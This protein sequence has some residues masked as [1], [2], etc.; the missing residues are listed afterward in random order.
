MRIQIVDLKI[1]NIK[2]LVNSLKKIPNVEIFVCKSVADCKTSGLTILPGIGK[3]GAASKPMFELGFSDYLQKTFKRGD[4]IL[5]ICLGMQ[6]LGDSSTESPGFQGLS[7]I[8]GSS[9]LLPSIV[10]ERI[11]NI[12]WAGIVKSNSQINFEAL[13]SNKD[14]YFVH[15]YFFDTISE[16]HIICKSK[17][18][19]FLFPSVIQNNNAIGVQFHPEKSSSVGNKLLFD[20]TKW[21]NE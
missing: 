21:A 3:F 5:G 18:G 9:K 2:S 8:P 20:I 17:Y 7:L 11:P 14:F 16:Q 12:G 13:V 6:L 10:G 1:N 19:E 4:K 15:S